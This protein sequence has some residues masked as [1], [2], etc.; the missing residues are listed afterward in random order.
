MWYFSMLESETC[1]IFQCWSLRH[2]V[3]FNAGVWDMWYFTT[4]DQS[5]LCISKFQIN[6]NV[7]YR[8]NNST[9]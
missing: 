9:L 1:G 3:F 2:V 8:F 5:K 6:V 7:L 4:L